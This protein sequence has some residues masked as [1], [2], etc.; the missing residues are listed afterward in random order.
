MA[1]TNVLRLAAARG[2]VVVAV[3]DAHW[4][5]AGSDGALSFAGRRLENLPL[6]FIVSER[7]GAASAVSRALDGDGGQTIDVGGLSLGAIR[8]LLN[9]RLAC[10]PSGKTLRR[11]FEACEGNP[12]LALELGTIYA[13]RGLAALDDYIPS[14]VRLEDVVGVRIE[15]L[16]PSV[17]RVLLAVAL[18]A[19]L[20]VEDIVALCGAEAVAEAVA[21]RQ[22]LVEHD[23]VR[24]AH[25]VLGAAAR[26]T[27]RARDRRR[28][29]A[30]LAAL[31][32]DKPLKARHLA[33]AAVAPSE[34]LAEEISAAA[35]VA[36]A[37]GAVED[38]V[39]LAEHALRLTPA[40]SPRRA[41]RI[42]ALAEQLVVSGDHERVSEL[43]LPLVDHL[44]RGLLRARAHLALGGT[45]WLRAHVDEPTVHFEQAL[46]DSEE[47]PVLHATAVARMV[48]HVAVGCVARVAEA[49]RWAV[50]VLPAARAGGADVEREVLHS[51]AW[52]RALRGAPI[53]DLAEQFRAASTTAFP[54]I[55]SIERVEAEQLSYRGNVTAAGIALQ[56]LL[57]LAEEGGEALAVAF[58]RL[59]LCEVKLRAGRWRA[60]SALLDE[61]HA[62]NETELIVEQAYQRCRAL[63]AAGRGHATEAEAWASDAVAESERRGLRWDALE[64][65]RVLGLARL[66]AGA[67][68]DAAATLWPVWER[69]TQQG[70]DE[71]GVF[72]VAPDLVEALVLVDEIHEAEAVTQR[73][74]RL[75]T[76]QEHPW[77]AATAKRCQALIRIAADERFDDAVVELEEAAAAYASLGL[78]WDAAR[79]LLL[80]GRGQRRRKR[81]GDARRTLA[82]A[83]ASFDELGSVGWAE[84]ARSE[85]DRIPGRRRR[86]AQELSPAERQVVTLAAEGRSNKEIAAGLFVTVNTVEA[87][88]THA[89]AKLGIRSRR[90]LSGRL[91][92]VD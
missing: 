58:L 76:A 33:L 28:L 27:A 92:A 12:F 83:A 70:V 89:Y 37:R 59:Q 26:A 72:P 47:D 73:L 79:S 88:L 35:S 44:P 31:V 84:G 30:E 50:D 62:S 54:I 53:S 67:P 10:T 66:M 13:E 82:A 11:L 90:Q 42:L 68:A 74:S 65:R 46:A 4:L 8:R 45:R 3:D 9:V 17:R 18:A 1:V 80:L 34:E 6:G 91:A 86:D 19:N 25:P 16:S 24:L 60:A 56:R 87:H 69:V 43:L 78:R 22:L 81:W 75:A 29:H 77:A 39:E 36:A 2:A 61:W 57:H 40:D 32:R 71:P 7:A 48:R 41:E 51:L 21:T 23:R 38:A 52:V 15:R 85:L 63:L 55:R 49:E 5:D 20:R 14:G 64:S